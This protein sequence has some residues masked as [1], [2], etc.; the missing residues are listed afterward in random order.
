MSGLD[1]TLGFAILFNDVDRD[2]LFVDSQASVWPYSVQKVMEVDARTGRCQVL[3]RFTTLSSP[4]AIEAHSA[5]RKLAH[6][7]Y[8]DGMTVE[9]KDEILERGRGSPLVISRLSRAES[10][11]FNGR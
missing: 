3:S 7:L 9:Q 11:T 8:H 6:A 5:G 4:D 2:A 1:E 10:P